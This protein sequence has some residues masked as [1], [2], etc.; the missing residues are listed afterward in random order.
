MTTFVANSADRG[1]SPADHSE[2]VNSREAY[3]LESVV[4]DLHLCG[5][6]IATTAMILASCAEKGRHNPLQAC[7]RLL[8]ADTNVIMLALRY[9]PEIGLAQE[10]VI[11]A[12][13][14]C[15][16]MLEEK[17]RL[18]PMMQTRQLSELQWE[19]LK[20][21]FPTW[22]RLAREAASVIERFRESLRGRIDGAYA[23]DARV[24]QKFLNDAAEG[25]P[26]AFDHAGNLRVPRMRQRRRAPRLFVQQD[27]TI[28]LPQGSFPARVEDASR[29]GLGLV[30]DQA[31]QLD[32][33]V[34]ITLQDGRTLKAVVV[35]QS[36]SRIGLSLETP[37]LSLDPLLIAHAN[38]VPLRSA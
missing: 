16:A 27:C 7:V 28:V 1:S 23:E 12:G 13:R 3:L 17:E 20:S 4:C 25:Q 38:A 30:C 10:L 34:S 32:Q 18:L 6:E 9:G 5:L 31:V 2:S 37:L 11:G 15:A 8:M 36:G 19:S 14:L 21:A 35:R 29:N 22:R 33:S 24:V 26:C